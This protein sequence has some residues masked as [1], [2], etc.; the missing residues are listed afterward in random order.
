MDLM[1]IAGNGMTYA[2]FRKLVDD[3]LAENKTTGN[4]Q[5]DLYL[6]HA[7][8]NQ[9]R[10]QRI[11]KTLTLDKDLEKTL[12]HLKRHITALMITEGWC[13]DSAQNAPVFGAM[14]KAGKNFETRIVL[15]DENLTLM[16]RYLTNGGRSIPKVIFIDT[17]TGKELATWGPRPAPA[18]K[19][20]EE[21]KAKNMSK[22][23]LSTA[24]HL[25][26]SKDRTKT[27]QKELEEILE[28]INA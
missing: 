12:N 25:W 20:M 16:D 18:Q 3:L 2:G 15:R 24:I 5:S 22:E 19:Q 28:K 13:G 8:L 23:D 14:D 27:L 4:D 9:H 21:A 10:M 1:T 6:S 7:R 26:Y 11:E 17:A